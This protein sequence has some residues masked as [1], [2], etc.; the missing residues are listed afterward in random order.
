M[1]FSM[2]L[3]II[4]SGIGLLFGVAGWLVPSNKSKF[5]IIFG[6]L[7]IVASTTIEIL[8]S[9]KNN[10]NIKDQQATI[11]ELKEKTLRKADIE[12]RINNQIVTNNSKITIRYND[13]QELNFKIQIKN[14]GTKNTAQIQL[15]LVTP[16]ISFFGNLGRMWHDQGKNVI[17]TGEKFISTDFMHDYVFVSPWFLYPGNWIGAG[18]CKINP[19]LIGNNV[20]IRIKMYYDDNTIDIREIIVEIRN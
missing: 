3:E 7:I 19:E 15:H 10:N 11:D 18:T 8:K 20:P 6:I 9:I 12:L 2:T 17:D 4:A 5:W 16:D 1:E 13:R 14:I